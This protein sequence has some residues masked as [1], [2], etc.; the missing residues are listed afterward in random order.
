VLFKLCKHFAI[1]VPV[2]FDA[3]SADV[4]FPF[5][6]CRILRQDDR[7]DIACSAQDETSM[8]KMQH[9][10]DE[11]LALMAKQPQLHVRW[12]STEPTAPGT[13]EVPAPSSCAP[14]RAQVS[15]PEARP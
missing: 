2:R 8:A 12:L 3:E 13:Q 5:G 6:T 15:L 9:V 10:M 11:H 14:S 1:K 7:L 4:D